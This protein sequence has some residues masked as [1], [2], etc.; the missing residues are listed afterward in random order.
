[1]SPRLTA[2]SRRRAALV[3]RAAAQRGE[4]GRLVERWHTPLTLAD[5]GVALVRSIRAHPLALAVGMALLVRV[6]GGRL[7]LWVERLWTGWQ[8]FHSLREQSAKG[9]V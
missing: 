5:R 8:L 7:G 3:A 6:P 2:I 9:R 4:V 1:M